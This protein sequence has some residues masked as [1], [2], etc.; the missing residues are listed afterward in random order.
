MK[1][2]YGNSIE[3]LDNDYAEVSADETANCIE[4]YGFDIGRWARLVG[5]RVSEG[6]DSSFVE[7]MS[8]LAV[9]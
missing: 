9:S 8:D 5:R 4:N 6:D 2:A 1:K 7:Q 3:W